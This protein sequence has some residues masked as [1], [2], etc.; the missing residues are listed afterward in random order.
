M[1]RARAGKAGV[2]PRLWECRAGLLVARPRAPWHCPLP[3]VADRCSGW[4]GLPDSGKT[5]TGAARGTWLLFGALCPRGRDS[6]CPPAAGFCLAPGS[7][8]SGLSGVWV[9]PR[10]R[11]QAPLPAV[12]APR[13]RAPA[14]LSVSLCGTGA[15]LANLLRPLG[16]NSERQPRSSLGVSGDLE[17][18]SLQK[19]EPMPNPD[20][21]QN[22]R[23]HFVFL[24]SA[25]V[26][27]TLSSWPSL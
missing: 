21:E 1:G 7:A 20:P 3:G 6:R 22:R 18:G 26:L 10:A 5:R 16:P 17:E 8:G 12:W 4:W 23:H 11:P 14:S 25:S 15:G 24:F 27:S 13:A 9:R 2:S 19:T